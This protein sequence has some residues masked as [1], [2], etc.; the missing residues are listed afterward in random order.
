MAK[1]PSQHTGTVNLEGVR[2]DWKTDVIYKYFFGV[3]D[4]AVLEFAVQEMLKTI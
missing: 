3:A 1:S 4:M 2:R